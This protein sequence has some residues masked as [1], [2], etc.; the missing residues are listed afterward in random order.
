MAKRDP[1]PVVDVFSDQGG[2]TAMNDWADTMA[3]RIQ[4]RRQDQRLRDTKFVEVERIKKANG[5]PLW[6]EVREK[7]EENCKAL[8]KRTGE[9]I[10]TFDI[11]EHGEVHVRANIDGKQCLLRLAFKMETGELEWVCGDC[12]GRGLWGL[13]VNNDG[14]VAF[15]SGIDGIPSNPSS[16]ANLVMTALLGLNLQ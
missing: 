1:L 11:S 9:Q 15:V 7:I 3:T 10:L 4:Q 12:R 13:S 16:I 2:K 14:S 5:E 8:N 6:R